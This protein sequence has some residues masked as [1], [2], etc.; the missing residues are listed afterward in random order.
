MHIERGGIAIFQ[1]AYQRY[2]T[3][4]RLMRDEAKQ[5]GHVLTYMPGVGG[6]ILSQE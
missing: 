2:T 6:V 5:K 1:L 3:R 4:G